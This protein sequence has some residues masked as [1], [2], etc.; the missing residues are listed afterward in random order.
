M[1]ERVRRRRLLQAGLAAGVPAMAG[2]LRLTAPADDTPAGTTVRDTETPTTDDGYPPGV[3]ADGV[4]TD[5]AAHHKE[6]LS[7]TERTVEHRYDSRRW[8]VRLAAS[9]LVASLPRDVSVYLAEGRTFQRQSV[10]G[11]TVYGYHDALLGEYARARLSGRETMRG[12]LRAGEFRPA[13]TRTTDGTTHTLVRADEIAD[14]QAFRESKPFDTNLESSE[15]PVDRFT[16]SGVV[17]P[18]GV[19]RELGVELP[20]VGERYRVSTAGIGATTV[21]EPDWAATARAQ[22]PEF[23]VS[24]VDDRQ[25]VRLAQTAGQRLGTEQSL[26]IGFSAYDTEN[27]YSG[28]HTGTTAPGTVFYLYKSPD[29]TGHEDGRL[30]VS[31]GTRPSTTPAGEWQERIGVS[32]RVDRLRLLVN[33]GVG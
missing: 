33:R 22:A 19:V 25:L 24:L 27:Y 31:K 26:R 13:G 3:S 20:A 15:L 9:R 17:S 7:G 10:A 32:L 1:D 28:R 6:A 18:D 30:G 12:L 11:Q 23:E 5:L 4:S 14:R 2:C 29:E 16:G 8:T 21:S